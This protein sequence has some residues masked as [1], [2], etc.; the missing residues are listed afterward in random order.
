MLDATRAAM[1]RGALRQDPDGEGLLLQAAVFGQGAASDRHCVADGVLQAGLPAGLADGAEVTLFAGAAGGKAL[2]QAHL[3]AVQAATAR[4]APAPPRGALWAEVTLPAPLPPLRL[5]HP[6]QADGSDGAGWTDALQSAV[7]AGPAVWATGAADLVPVLTGDTIALAAVDGVPD[8]DGPGATPRITPRDGEDRATATLRMIERA[9]YALRFGD[10]MAG[11]AGRHPGRPV[12]TM[13][14]ARKAAARGCG[15]AGSATPH[16]PAKGVSP[17]DQLWLTLTNRSG[18]ALDVTVFYLAQDFSLTPLR[19][20]N[21][22]SN[23]LLPGEAVRTGLMIA[24][25]TLPDAIEEILV[26]AV[27]ATDTGARADLARLAT[28]D[29]LRG[30]PTAANPETGAIDALPSPDQTPRG[31]TARRP[32]LSFLR[33]TLRILAS[34]PAE[35]SAPCGPQSSPCAC[36]PPS[37][38]PRPLP[39]RSSTPR[40]PRALPSPGP[41]TRPPVPP[42]PPRVR[43]ESGAA[44][45]AW[46]W[47]VALMIADVPL[48]PEGQFCGGSMVL[49]TWVLTAAH[50]IHMERADGTWA[51]L[52]PDVIRVLIGTNT[53]ATGKGDIALIRLAR[54]PTAAY[55]TVQIPDAAFGDTLDQPGVVTTVTG[56]G[57]TDGGTQTDARLPAEIQVM[58][59]DLCNA[60]LRDSRAEVAGR[61]FGQA[62][63]RIRRQGRRCLCAVGPVAGQGPAADVREFPV[64][65]HLRG[66]QDR[67]FGRQRR[68]AGGGAGGWQLHSGGG[69]QLGSVGGRGQGL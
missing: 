42:P 27:E 57:L 20:A 49:D 61:A 66:R 22:L 67:L 44:D 52:A 32:P 21:D 12:I 2:A 64:F 26:V 50:C 46:P 17:C 30:G 38:P 45:G 6:V 18:K 19:P 60:A 35:R 48:S 1:Q 9:A 58:D 54:K 3:H 59:R 47:Q 40:C 23:R 43:G 4:L 13:D 39:H 8:A 10:V 14:I 55:A 56:W 68:P 24:P 69:G 31:F 51:D 7:E 63:T 34:G 33:Q 36:F 62:V 28:P 11:L 29:R 65:G 25:D 41:A 15:P 37:P 16:D 5:A 53:L